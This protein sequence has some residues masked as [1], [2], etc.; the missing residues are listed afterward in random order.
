[1]FILHSSLV[2]TGF[3]PADPT[4]VGTYHT[5][6]VSS[7]GF[8]LASET[9]FLP[10]PYVFVFQSPHI[11]TTRSPL[12]THFCEATTLYFTASMI[13][14]TSQPPAKV[15]R[16]LPLHPSE[17]FGVNFGP[18]PVCCYPISKESASNRTAFSS[19]DYFTTTHSRG[20]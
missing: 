7:A 19:V 8:R 17:R 20:S 5:L 10:L 11:Y 13:F 18:S 9:F 15:E 1:M 14:F 4:S 12:R 6:V 3:S 2:C 16:V